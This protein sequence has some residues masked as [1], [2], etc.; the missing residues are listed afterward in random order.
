MLE[1]DSTIAKKNTLSE[2]R[3]CYFQFEFCFIT[4]EGKS[5]LTLL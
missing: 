1:G 2:H 3:Q 5:G 4:Y